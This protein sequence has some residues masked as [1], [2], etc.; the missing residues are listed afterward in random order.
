MRGGVRKSVGVGMHVCVM[1]MRM[2]TRTQK[3]GGEYVL[4][5]GC[6]REGT[7]KRVHAKV[8]R[9]CGFAEERLRACL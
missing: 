8:V 3:R 1:V 9:V 6:E 4:V 2:S 7:C 5:R